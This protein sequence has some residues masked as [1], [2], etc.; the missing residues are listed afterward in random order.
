MLS[1]P[2]AGSPNDG[3]PGFCSDPPGRD[4]LR[5]PAAV[6]ELACGDC[7]KLSVLAARRIIDARAARKV[8]LCCTVTDDPEEHV[9]LRV[10]GKLRDP[11]AE[12][13]MPPRR[14]GAYIA[15]P[16]WEA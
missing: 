10:D 3:T 16:V 1:G 12:A 13:G 8:E 4:V 14:I 15:E 2:P 7:K 9:F 11:A 5:S 6:L